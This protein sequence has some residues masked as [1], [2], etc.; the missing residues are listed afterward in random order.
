M[1]IDRVMELEVK[2][3]NIIKDLKA[4][5]SKKNFHT[6][7]QDDIR[8]Y[9]LR[10]ETIKNY[11]QEVLKLSTIGPSEL[12]ECNELSTDYMYLYTFL[13]LTIE[14]YN[15]GKKGGESRKKQ[16]RRNKYYNKSK[17]TK[18]NKHNKGSNK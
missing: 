8:Q 6:T 14:K 4:L 11:F 1:N 10:G 12:I 2:V 17:N 16:K 9:I 5:L 13:K 7:I 18:C 3:D 15:I